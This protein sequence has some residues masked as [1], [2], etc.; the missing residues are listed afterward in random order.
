M[1]S[2]AFP[3]TIGITFVSGVVISLLYT[4]TWQRFGA[5]QVTAFVLVLLLG[6]NVSTIGLVDIPRSSFYLIGEMYGLILVIYLAFVTV[7]VVFE[8]KRLTSTN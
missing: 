3:M 6:L 4:R 1:V 2:Q 5:I 7:F 8:R